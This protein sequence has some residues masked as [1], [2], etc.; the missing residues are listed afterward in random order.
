MASRLAPIGILM[1]ITD[2]KQG[3]MELQETNR[4][5]AEALVELQ[6]TQQKLIQEER[7]RAWARWRAALRMISTICWR[8]LWALPNCCFCTLKAGALRRKRLIISGEFTRPPRV[9]P[10]WSAACANFIAIEMI[11]NYNWRLTCTCGQADYPADPAPLE[12]PIVSQG[13]ACSCGSLTCGP[14]PLITGNK[15]ELQEMLTNLMLNAVDALVAEGRILI[16]V[17]TDIKTN[18][19]YPTD[20]TPTH[21]VLEI[22]DTGMGMNEETQRR[23]FEPFFSTK[24][25]T[26]LVWA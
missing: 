11:P 9:P 21:V 4:R 1:D 12:R 7:L 10:P 3:E 25:D 13:G 22:S 16:R 8:R 18:G 6:Q 15:A 20:Q 14:C 2:R 23:C 24:G 5:L 17:F 26:A 19:P